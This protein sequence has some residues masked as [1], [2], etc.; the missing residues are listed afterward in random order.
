MDPLLTYLLFISFLS[1]WISKF[2]RF[3]E[4]LRLKVSIYT[5]KRPVL[6]QKT[7]SNTSWIVWIFKNKTRPEKKMK[8]ICFGV[9]CRMC[10]VILSMKSIHL[11]IDVFKHSARKST[12][13]LKKAPNGKGPK[14]RPRPSIYWLQNVSCSGVFFFTRSISIHF[15]KKKVFRIIRETPQNGWRK[16]IENPPPKKMMI[17]GA[18]PTPIFG[19]IQTIL[20]G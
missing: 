1:I 6:H 14:H 15:W 4:P 5:K 10:K 8:V 7:P 3:S 13:N 16:K 9:A 2:I 11:H 17:W 12:W 18:H 19:N 20:V